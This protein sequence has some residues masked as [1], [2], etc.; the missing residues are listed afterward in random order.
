MNELKT[1]DPEG[2]ILFL[3]S[4]FSVASKNIS[5]NQLPSG[6]KLK[7]MFAKIVG[8]DENSYNFQTLADEVA[9]T[10]NLYQ[11][12]YETFTVSD[13]SEAQLELLKLPWLRIY[14]TNYDDAVEKGLL[15]LKGTY[16][17]FNYDDKKPKKLLPGS[18]V[19]LHGTI[20]KTDRDNVLDQLIMM[21]GRIS[22]SISRIRFGMM[23]LK[24]MSDSRQIASSLGIVYQ[25][26]I[27][28][29]SYSQYLELKI[30]LIL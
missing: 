23:N 20:G 26:I 5:G 28:Q 3:G 22:G 10:T 7:S 15:E 6:S 11:L 27:Y 2:S 29:L 21:K 17:S 16:K 30:R 8:V 18:I 14:T 24:E 12:L 9:R 4:G 19:H 1:L 25:T 13:L